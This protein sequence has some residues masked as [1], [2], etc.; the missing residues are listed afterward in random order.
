MRPIS[1]SAATASAAA[2]VAEDSGSRRGLAGR[3]PVAQQA[4]EIPALA[5]LENP[6]VH[7]GESG[8]AQKQD[9]AG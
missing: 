1:P 4:V 6:G 9:G 2:G 8:I 3:A 5:P 7:Q